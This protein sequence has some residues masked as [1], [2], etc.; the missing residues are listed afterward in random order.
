PAATPLGWRHAAVGLWALGVLL[1]FLRRARS[2]LALIALA[3]GSRELD[4]P[5]WEAMTEAIGDELGLRRPVRLLVHPDASTPGTFGTLRPAVLLPARAL[6]WSV[7]R[8]RA[9]LL[10][11][12]AHVRRHDVLVH[13]LT[14]IARDLL[15]CHPLAWMAERRLA[16]LR[17]AACDDA[18]LARGARAS[19][20]AAFLLALARR[21]AASALLP[22]LALHRG[23]SGLEL[24][25]HHILGTMRRSSQPAGRRGPRIAATAAF[26]A[27]AS[28]PALSVELVPRAPERAPQPAEQRRSADR[29]RDAEATRKAPE[30]ETKKAA[31]SDRAKASST[32]RANAKPA[33]G[34]KK[35]AAPAPSPKRAEVWVGGL[36][37]DAELRAI[38]PGLTRKQL[39]EALKKAKKGA[40][41]L[42]TARDLAE[43]PCADLEAG[44]LERIVQE[45]L[46]RVE[47][48]HGGKARIGRVGWTVVEVPKP[49]RDADTGEKARAKEPAGTLPK[50]ERK[51]ASMRPAPKRAAVSPPEREREARAPRPD[52]QEEQERARALPERPQPPELSRAERKLPRVRLLPRTHERNNFVAATFN[53]RYG[54][55]DDARLVN[56][57]WDLELRGYNNRPT[58]RVRIV[59]DDVGGIADLGPVDLSRVSKN[60]RRLGKY[61]LAPDAPMQLGHTYVVHSKDSRF[62][63]WAAFRVV[64]VD[65]LG[66]AELAWRMLR[67]DSGHVPGYPRPPK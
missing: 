27:F 42:P 50:S 52:K 13:R 49:R 2:E 44:D 58:F 36:P 67:D 26:L 57:S 41:G 61:A 22:A 30:A 56:N 18:V 37:T 1:L 34:K 28:L 46:E 7:D 62:D 19:S 48:E 55:R 29:S 64:G 16:L 43:H 12:L 3:R 4:S 60:A 63:Y 51:K 21:P 39:D 47:R 40:T 15:W 45:A 23:A 33:E 20:Y 31:S 14:G 65:A 66:T 54:T 25:L 35:P 38:A 59:T 53:F 5:V 11:E 32:R 6:D 9:A 17:E 10:H 8:R 24:R